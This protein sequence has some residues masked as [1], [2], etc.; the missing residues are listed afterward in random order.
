MSGHPLRSRLERGELILLDGALGT[1][2]E[3]RG[4]ATPLPLWSAGALLTAP[5]VVRAIHEDY[6]RAGSDL[7]TADTFRATPRAFGRAGRPGEAGRAL[8][9]AVSLLREARGRA[10]AARDVLL[11]GAI[12]PLEDCYQP[13]LAPPSETA[14]REHGLQATL[15]ARAGVDVILVETMNTIGEARA[16]V[17]GAKPAGLPVLVSFICREEREILSGEPLVDAVRAV[18]ELD[19]DAILVNCTPPDLVTRCLE[20]IARTTV[21]PRGAYANAGTPD[22]ETGV[23]R[24]DDRWSPE[25]F[26]AAATAWVRGGAQI[27]GGC[28]GT[29]PAHIRAIRDAIPPVLVE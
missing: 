25:R 21:L 28:C 13:A 1:E 9:L 22:M 11:A 16:A 6:I 12:A 10:G 19:P 5:D 8:D 27:V 7:V 2:L 29:T 14:E 17:R 26:A 15:L 23:W 24:F 20:E 18:E 4:V 3:R